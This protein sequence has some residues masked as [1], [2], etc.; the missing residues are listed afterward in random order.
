MEVTLLCI[1]LLLVLGFG[2]GLI[3]GAFTTHVY[4]RDRLARAWL[5]GVK[6]RPLIDEALTRYRTR[7]KANDC[8]SLD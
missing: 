6:D 7:S 8:H 5:Q 4:Y 3:A 1:Y 2:A